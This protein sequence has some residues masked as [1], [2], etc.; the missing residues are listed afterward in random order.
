MGTVQIQHTYEYSYPR[1]LIQARLFQLYIYFLSFHLL[2]SL[3]LSLIRETPSIRENTL[4]GES[5]NSINKMTTVNGNLSTEI[6]SYRS[7]RVKL[8]KHAYAC[9][10]YSVDG[11]SEVSYYWRTFCACVSSAIILDERFSCQLF[12]QRDVS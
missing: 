4:P 9:V 1:Q 2:S 6:R 3:F 7:L 12:T 11:A 8:A 5:I 10:R